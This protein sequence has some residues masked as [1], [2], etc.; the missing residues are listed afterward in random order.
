MKTFRQAVQS[1]AFTITAD[2]TLQSNSGADD[3]A[4]Q[5]E[6]LGPWVDGI[7]VSDSPWAWLQ[8]SAVAAASL[9]LQQGIDPIPILTCRDRNR[10]AL[11]SDLLGLRA[12]GVS[13]VLLMRGHKIPR[14]HPLKAG[15]IFDTSGRELVA[16]AAGL[17]ES[18][19]P[20]ADKEF[21]IGIGARA[22]RPPAHGWDAKSLQERSRAGAR[23]LQT[24]LCFNLD[25]LRLYI[26]C[27]VAARL[28]WKYSV[29]V[30]LT[31]LPSAATAKWLKKN[32]TDSRIPEEVIRRLE[33]AADP[34]RE[35]IEICAELMREIAAIP[36]VSGV[37]LMTMGNPR[38]IRDAIVASGLRH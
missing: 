24:Q 10:I 27:L 14:D 23:F 21:F 17:A 8:M 36:G 18:D 22:F 9:V 7:Q 3:V 12:L 35:G 15:M 4:R 32:L 28:T 31:P 33:E 11:H 37:N 13:S 38:S 2:L 26:Q 1:E 25:I 20:A 34:E 5:L 16:I 30:S 19:P 29:M 6:L